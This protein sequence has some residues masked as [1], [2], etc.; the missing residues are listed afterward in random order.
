MV[1]ICFSVKSV[2]KLIEGVIVLYGAAFIF[3]G[4][5]NTIYFNFGLGVLVRRLIW[6]EYR[7]IT[8][9]IILGF[10]VM[11]FICR[12]IKNYEQQIVKRRHTYNVTLV[13][14]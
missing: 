1:F 5:L 3:G 12:L 7:N 8:V 4:I 13:H 6:G 9:I 2:R 10:A 14:V 11:I